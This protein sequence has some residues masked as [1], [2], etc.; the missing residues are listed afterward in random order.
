MRDI[1]VLESG[2]A[3]A[4]AETVS[5]AFFD[6]PLYGYVEPD[7]TKRM[8]VIMPL[9]RMM[10]QLF[11]RSGVTDATADTKGLVLWL[12]PGKKI[13]PTAML[14][15]GALALPFRT[16]LGPLGRLMSAMGEADKAHEEALGVPHWY[17]AGATVDPSV[18]GQ[19]IGT[20][21]VE[22][23]LT[24]V[25]A[26]GASCYLETSKERNVPYWQRF[27]FEVAFGASLGKG[28]VPYWGMIRPADSARRQHHG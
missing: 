24:R 28:T 10:V 25:D 22:H 9:N 5:R 11:L 19:G 1:V 21:L 17:L 12:P 2:S 13:S 8:R 6:D 18:H 3:D 16:G 14:R 4:A 27:G 23:G 26:E 15:S 7:E 20:A